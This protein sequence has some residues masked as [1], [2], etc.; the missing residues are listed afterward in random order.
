VHTGETAS[1]IGTR[2]RVLADA[3]CFEVLEPFAAALLIEDPPFLLLQFRRKDD[4][5]RLFRHL[6]HLITAPSL[7]ARVPRENAGH[8]A[9]D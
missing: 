5:D 6:F 7:G 4:G 9:F 8:P 1:E 3:D 2:R